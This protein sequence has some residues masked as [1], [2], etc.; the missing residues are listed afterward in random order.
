M[1]LSGNH[2]LTLIFDTGLS[3]KRY[4]LFKTLIKLLLLFW[5]QKTSF[6]QH[7]GSKIFLYFITFSFTPRNFYLISCFFFFPHAWLS[8]VSNIQST[9]TDLF[10]FPFPVTVSPRD[11]CSAF[12]IVDVN[13]LI[14]C[15]FQQIKRLF[16]FLILVF[17]LL[18]T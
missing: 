13:N 14:K 15:S 12:Q 7:S 4:M 1:N 2:T 17:L 3:S 5:V 9:M 6:Y 18:T 8:A 10:L 16:S 11:D